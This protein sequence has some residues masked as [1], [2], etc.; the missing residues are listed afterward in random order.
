MQGKEEPSDVGGLCW[1]GEASHIL[2]WEYLLLCLEWILQHVLGFFCWIPIDQAAGISGTQVQN[3]GKIKAISSGTC[4]EEEC[5]KLPHDFQMALSTQPNA[6]LT[7]HCRIPNHYGILCY[8]I[9]F[10]CYT[11]SWTATYLLQQYTII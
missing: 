9:M 10:L 4:T 7:S 1:P 6:A 2:F 8:W 5:T 11:V 3:V